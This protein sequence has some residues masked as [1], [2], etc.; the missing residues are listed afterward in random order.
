MCCN[1][2]SGDAPSGGYG[3]YVIL[4]VAYGRNYGEAA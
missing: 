4:Y 3:V 1:T 2:V